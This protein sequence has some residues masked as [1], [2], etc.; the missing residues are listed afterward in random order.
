MAKHMKNVFYVMLFLTQL[1]SNA[2]FA[3]Y[4][5]VAGPSASGGYVLGLYNIAS[6]QYCSQFT[7]ASSVFPNGLVDVV[8][9]LNGNVVG[10]GI[11]GEIL[12][13]SPPS[14]TPVSSASIPAGAFVTGAVLAPSGN[15]Y[16][17]TYTLVGG[18]VNPKIY[19][20]NP[21]S[22]S[23]TLVGSFP[24]PNDVSLLQPI[25]LN[26]ILYA[27]MI[28]Y[29]NP[30][31]TSFHLVSVTLGNPMVLNIVD[32]YPIYCGAAAA[33]ITSGPYTGIYGGNL[34]PSCTGTDIYQSNIGGGATFQC[35]VSPGGVVNGLG[36]VPVGFP[37][38]ANCGCSTNAGNVNTPNASLCTNASFTFTN[39]GGFLESNDIKQFVL[40]TNPSD[41]AGSIVA[42]SNSP[43]F[44]FAPPLVT[45]V[46][47]Y[48]AAV[49]GNNSGGIVDL[50]DPCLDFSNATQVIWRPLPTVTFTAANPNVCAG[51]CTTV[52]ATFTGTAP[53]TL[54]YTSAGGS[55]V[56]QTFPG[57]SGTFQVC[58]PVGAAPGSFS[59]AATSLVDANCSCP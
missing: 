24:T 15:I 38:S 14:P 32:T 35:S 16:V 46:T 33:S 49:A 26:G 30:G 29:G 48:A 13:F 12:T 42:I 40:F 56:T 41:T 52:T 8:P 54:T 51:A 44:P 39:T 27:F 34:D 3:Q 1:N 57:N 31:G 37:G 53:F 23:V 28:D 6:C 47:Y 22:N 10:F 43:S 25:Y 5:Y 55:A 45:G 50:S 4:L 9:L 18:V 7:V 19:E 21:T 2:L 11:Q 17:T 36:S 59:V 58:V 20:Y